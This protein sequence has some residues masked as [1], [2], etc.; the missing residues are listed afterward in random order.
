[1]VSVNKK[2]WLSMSVHK[3]EMGYFKG[4]V[5]NFL[6]HPFLI[7]KSLIKI[8]NKQDLKRICV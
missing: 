8:I 5:D 7:T 1:M 4:E 6:K 2:L 3:T